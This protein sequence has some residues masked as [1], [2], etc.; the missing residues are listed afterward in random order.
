[1][2]FNII[3]IS[4]ERIHKDNY[5]NE[6]SL[7]DDPVV[8]QETDYAGEE[9][10]YHEVIKNIKN[11]LAPFATVNIRK[12]TIRFRSQQAVHRKFIK[13]T[14]ATINTFR[15]EMSEKRY[16]QAE[17]KLRHGVTEP[18][19]IDDLFYTDHAKKFSQVISD[20]LGGYISRTL[21]IGAILDAHA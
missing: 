20:Y 3:Q 6:E 8:L 5:I 13:A 9:K 12:R 21:Y 14:N 10:E 2:H 18:F 7:Y 4:T 19:E 15:K 17:C 16:W 1:M 11:E